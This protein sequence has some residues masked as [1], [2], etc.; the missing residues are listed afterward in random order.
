M[1]KYHIAD[2]LTLTEVVMAAVVVGLAGAGADAV[3]ALAAFLIGEIC[4]A[5]DG[6]CAR[7]W[8]YPK[9]GKFRWWREKAVEIDQLSDILLALAV[10]FYV[11]LNLDLGFALLVAGTAIMIAVPVQFISGWLARNGAKNLADKLVLVRRYLYLVGLIILFVTL[12]QNAS[13]SLF[14]REVV[15]G[16]TVIAALVMIVVKQNRLTQNK[17][18]L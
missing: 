4:D 3:F 1:K 17:T 14:A 13:L 2:L 10:L 16:L 6:I 18:P 9:D 8:H 5:F 12:V 11:G 15:Y 7:K